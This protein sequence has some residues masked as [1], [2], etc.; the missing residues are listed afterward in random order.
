[1]RRGGERGDVVAGQDGV[2]GDGGGG[3]S[4]TKS[5]QS[6]YKGVTKAQ[7]RHSRKPG[8]ERRQSLTP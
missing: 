2:C 6:R 4:G 7:T 3:Y 1:M 5:L 8:T